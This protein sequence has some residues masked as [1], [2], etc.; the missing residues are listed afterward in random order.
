VSSSR[1]SDKDFPYSCPIR[2]PKI[3]LLGNSTDC[4]HHAHPTADPKPL[5]VAIVGAG[6]GGLTAAIALR[7]NGHLVRVSLA[8]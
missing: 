2:V 6:L 4:G 1:I 7:R 3:P 8:L 5:N